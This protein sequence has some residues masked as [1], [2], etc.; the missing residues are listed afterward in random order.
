MALSNEETRYDKNYG[1]QLKVRLREEVNFKELC[2]MKATYLG[3]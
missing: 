2:D 1:P 3:L